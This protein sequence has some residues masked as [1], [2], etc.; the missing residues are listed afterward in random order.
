MRQKY[1]IYLFILE[2]AGKRD[3]LFR[4]FNP[5][6]TG[7]YWVVKRRHMTDSFLISQF[8]LYH[9]GPWIFSTDTKYKLSVEKIPLT[10]RLPFQGRIVPRKFRNGLLGHL[11]LYLIDTFYFTENSLKKM[12]NF[13]LNP[14]NPPVPSNKNRVDHVYKSFFHPVNFRPNQAS[15]G[16]KLISVFISVRTEHTRRFSSSLPDRLTHN[17]NVFIQLMCDSYCIQRIMTKRNGSI[18]II[19]WKC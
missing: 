17:L 13:W 16:R 4:I 1:T 7:F 12:K 10:L 19:T 5:P 6:N 15:F 18:V 8:L 3:S 11:K 14:K 9:D 2:V